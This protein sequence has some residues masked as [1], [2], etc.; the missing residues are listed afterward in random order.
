MVHRALLVGAGGMGHA[1]LRTDGGPSH[2]SRWPAWSTSTAVRAVDGR[3]GVRRRIGDRVH[4][5]RRGDPGHL[6][7][8]ADRRRRPDLAPSGDH[9]G[10]ARRRAGDRREAGDGD[11]GAGDRTRGAQP[12]HRRP[13]RRQ[14]EPPLRTQRRQRGRGDRGDRPART[15]DGDVRARR[16]LRRLPRGDGEP[17][18]VRHVDPPPRLP[19]LPDGRTRPRTG[20]GRG[21]VLRRVL[22]RAGTGS[23]AT[24][25]ARS[26]CAS[27]PA[28]TPPTPAPGARW[29]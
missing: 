11:A 7:G 14:P 4:R 15:G 28:P 10:A 24:R 8:P 22:R 29:G 13:V 27:S 21:R 19:A 20:T 6:A 12:A 16:A 9:R 5:R 26:R 2:G 18:A 17:A 25:A 3:A 23:R 1:W